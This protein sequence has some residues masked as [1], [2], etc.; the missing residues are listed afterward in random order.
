[1]KTARCLLPVV[2]VLLASAAVAADRDEA[3]FSQEA[4]AAAKQRAERIKAEIASLDDHPWAGDYFYGE[5][6]GTIVSFMLAP[7]SGY[8]FEWDADL[9][10]FDRNYGE[11]SYRSGT[12]ALSFTFPNEREGFQGVADEFIPVSWGKRTYLVP[13]DDIVG[14]C[15]ECNARLEPRKSMF[16]R[17]LLRRKD[18][19]KK[20]KG[21]PAVPEDYRAYLLEQPIEAEITALGSHTTRPGCGDLTFED[22]ELTI[23]KGRNDGVLPGMTLYVVLPEDLVEWVTVKFVN[24]QTAEGIMTQIGGHVFGPEVGWKLSTKPRF[25]PKR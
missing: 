11:V 8:V 16:G 14:F 22:T 19:K 24:D 25:T 7:E 4:E 10:L 3:K 21:V 15:N 2:S 20:A 12:I 23:G 18:E 13:A 17:Y 1:M 5:G 9:G 6:L